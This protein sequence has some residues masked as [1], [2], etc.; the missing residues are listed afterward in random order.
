MPN[1]II[2]AAATTLNSCLLL[3]RLPDG[4]TEPELAS[5]DPDVLKS[6]ITFS[7]YLIDKRHNRCRGD[8]SRHMILTIRTQKA[9]IGR[10]P[11]G[12]G[13]DT[14]PILENLYMTDV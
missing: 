12:S 6:S 7:E 1:I 9:A 8:A 14:M 3:K 5:T 11:T 10:M 2:D 13:A 4:R